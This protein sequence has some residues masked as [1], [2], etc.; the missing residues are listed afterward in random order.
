M[1][2]GVFIVDDHAV[3]R[4]GLRTILSRDSGIEVIGEARNGDEALSNYPKRAPD[5]VLMEMKM[6]GRNGIETLVAIRERDS[7][8]KV[9]VFTSFAE[10]S[11]VRDAV[12]AGAS[13]Y[14]LKDATADELLQAVRAVASGHAWLHPEAQRQ[15]LEWLR[16]PASPVSQ[17]TIRE[18]SVFSLLAGGMSNKLIARK[19]DLTEGTVKGYVSQI[20]GKLG[21]ADRTQAALLALRLGSSAD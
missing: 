19:L 21:V 1:R 17:L 11:H 2:I 15:M 8:A 4:E 5:V 10:E 12:D 9:L 14:L 13:G 16:R 6:P 20:L 18:R 7:T 3:V